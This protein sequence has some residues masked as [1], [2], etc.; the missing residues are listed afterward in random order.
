ME[1]AL[2]G[3][4]ALLL[5]QTLA[6]LAASR[7]V[8]LV[9]RRLGQPMVVAEI[10]AGILLGPSLL[11]WV[12][13]EAFATVFAPDSLGTLNLVAQLGLVLF[14]FLVGLELEPSLLRGRTHTSIAISH[15]SII[16]PFALGFGLAY[17]MD[18]TPAGGSSLAFP[19]FMGAAMSITAFPVLA[20]ILTERRLLRT[21]V[22]AVTIAC[23][24]VDDVTAW[25]ILAFVVAAARAVG[26]EG[27]LVTTALSLLYIAVVVFAVRPL[28]R[29]IAARVAHPETMS[30]N[31][32]AVVLAMALVS[33]W[34]TETIGIHALFGAFLL[35]AVVPK[36]GGFARALSE[37][38]EDLVGVILLPL[39]FAYSGLRTEIGLL[40]TAAE[41]WMTGLVI[42]VACA[43]KFGGSAVAARLTGLSW[44]ESS[45]LGV[46]MN[47]RGLME[48]IVLNI[49]L[50]LGVI[51]PTIF[52]MMVLMALFTT[53]ITS[54]LL[55][56][57]Y[58]PSI[59]ARDL[60]SQVPAS[61]PTMPRFGILA[62]VSN[63][64][65]APGLATLAASLA[66]RAPERARVWGLHLIDPTEREAF[67]VE[68]QGDDAD[69]A[70][71][72]PFNER[73]RALELA[74][75][76]MSF[77]SSE[78]G[79]D[80][81]RVA[82]AR[83]VDLVL[84]GWHKPVLSQTHL[85]GIVHDVLIGA[86]APVGIFVDRGF[87]APR[88]VLVPWLGSDAEPN[89]QAALRLATRLATTTGASVTVLGIARPGVTVERPTEAPDGALFV[90]VGAEDPIAAIIDFAARGLEPYDLIVVGLGRAWGLPERRF[91]PMSLGLTPE[92]LLH[93]APTSVLAIRDRKN[94]REASARVEEHSLAEP[95]PLSVARTSPES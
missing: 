68:L 22:G 61:P 90:V 83:D 64:R 89:D 17:G 28:M 23:A 11:G 87:E 94:P 60:L 34:V 93:A 24:A 49:G 14:M 42:L 80:I 92:R 71:L 39:F 79:T 69:V 16:V 12:A 33:A 48:L 57:I 86:D 63:P 20:R 95:H 40:D 2:A 30:Q 55:S 35:G 91:L 73:A 25:C 74:V 59:M 45:A 75:R 13:P 78:P 32:V 15:T 58:P 51:S 52:S 4:F 29:R 6:I 1:H 62:C 53:F 5:I 85:G 47:T 21:R 8:G 72:A 26:V 81:C 44:R 67:E 27:A 10:I 31:V 50:D 37:K 46:L 66:G 88:R 76:P 82:E 70:A 9:T 3:G 84:L 18:H 56:V 36:D 7:L 38:L 65:S 41:W 19:L 77:A 43:G 54:P